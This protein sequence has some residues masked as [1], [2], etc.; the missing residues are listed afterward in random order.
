MR[1]ISLVVVLLAACSSST[2]PVPLH[3][4]TI[5]LVNH[6]TRDSRDSLVVRWQDQDGHSIDLVA[7]SGDTRCHQ[8]PP[9]ILGAA[10]RLFIRAPEYEFTNPGDPPTGVTTF[11]GSFVSPPYFTVQAQYAF[12]D[13]P[14]LDFSHDITP[15]C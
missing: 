3:D 2:D 6:N 10:V 9:R 11:N 15:A 5:L 4:P 12:P 13:A 7:L 8:F 1:C 14:S